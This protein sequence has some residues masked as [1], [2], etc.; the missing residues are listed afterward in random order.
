MPC[1]PR[2]ASFA[3]GGHCS[4]LVMPLEHVPVVVHQ[5]Q[6]NDLVEVGFKT[7]FP[8]HFQTVSCTFNEMSASAK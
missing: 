4:S 8:L 5:C 2:G 3:L 7:I 6:K 1:F